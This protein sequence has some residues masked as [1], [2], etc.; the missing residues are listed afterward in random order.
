MSYSCLLHVWTMIFLNSFS[1]SAFDCSPLLLKKKQPLFTGSIT[2]CK[3]LDISWNPGYSPQYSLW[4]F[5]EMISSFNFDRLLSAHGVIR[6]FLCTGFLGQL[7]SF[8]FLICPTFMI[9]LLSF[10]EC[11]H[12]SIIFSYADCKVGFL[13]TES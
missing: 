1:P 4:S 13:R 3:S 5:L 10:L 2:S 9:I 6:G 12:F 8:F 7:H 11:I